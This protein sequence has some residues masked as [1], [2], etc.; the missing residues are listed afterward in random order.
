MNPIS[1]IFKPIIVL[2]N[3]FIDS[4]NYKTIEAIKRGFF[5]VV[6][7]MCIVGIIIGYRIGSGE[8]KIKSSPLT[9]YVN[10]TFRLS[11][12]KTDGDFSEILKSEMLNETPMN[13]F[14]K[15]DFPLRENLDKENFNPE[16][17]KGIMETD[18]RIPNPNLADKPF[19][20]ETT[21]ETA[22]KFDRVQ[23]NNTINILDKAKDGTIIDEN[24]NNAIFNFNN[25]KPF[26]KPEIKNPDDKNIIRILDKD[27]NT[28]P[29]P[30]KKDTGII[31]K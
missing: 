3:R 30:L 27:S 20:P 9:D 13:N 24:K 21:I 5:F 1:K 2:I 22:P 26:N 18:N 7:V 12:S 25:E 17:K 8:A 23:S 29:Q 28:T 10:D 16:F 19:K 31:D 4:L 6:F 14:N 11:I 15:Y